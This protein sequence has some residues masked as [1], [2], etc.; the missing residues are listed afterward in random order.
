MHIIHVDLTVKPDK[1][2]AFVEATLDN[3]RGS[4]E[5]PGCIRFDVF[6]TADDPTRFRLDEVYCDEAAL[7]EHRETIHYRAW[8]TAMEDILA[9]P[10]SK[11]VFKSVY[12]GEEGWE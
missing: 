4:V 12:P 1:V 3:A 7:A 10:R 5:E 2:D 11:V 6:Q 8:A 9:A